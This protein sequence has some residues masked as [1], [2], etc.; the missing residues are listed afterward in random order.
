MEKM[1]I[2]VAN[3]PCTYREA[4]TGALS[5]LRPH[6]EVST[7]EPGG[8]DGEIERLHPHLVVCSCPCAAAQNGT[9]SW[10][11]LYPDGDNR[12]EIV[13]A[14]ERATVAGIRFGDLLSI[15]DSTE[16]LCRSA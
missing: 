9:L 4:I 6:V 5:E 16:L 1:R 11:M 12:A 7:I 13:T 3:D 15:V 10:V 2:L 14:G 8:L